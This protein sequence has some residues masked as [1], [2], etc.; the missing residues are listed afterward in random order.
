MQLAFLSPRASS[1]MSDQT[2]SR[3]S[4]SIRGNKHP[5]ESERGGIYIRVNKH[6]RVALCS[7]WCWEAANGGPLLAGRVPKSPSLP[8]TVCPTRRF[9]PQR[10]GQ[11]RR[12]AAPALMLNI[13]LKDFSAGIKDTRVPARQQALP[14]RSCCWSEIW[15]LQVV[16]IGTSST[17]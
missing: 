9:L 11:R 5:R 16:G 13:V 7:C 1:W 6:L 3:A 8:A 17:I 15:K 10:P 4:W 12:T 2:G 14:N